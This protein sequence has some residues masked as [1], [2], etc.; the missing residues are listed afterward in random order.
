MGSTRRG[1]HSFGPWSDGSWS[2]TTWRTGA[3]TVTFSW[4]RITAATEPTAMPGWFPNSAGCSSVPASPCS[5]RNFIPPAK[6]WP[7]GTAPSGGC[8]S[9]SAA[10]TIPVKP[11]RRS[12]PWPTTQKGKSWP[13]SS[14]A[15][16]TASGPRSKSSAPA[17]R[18]SPT[19]ARLP[20]SPG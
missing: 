20:T 11:P 7:N 10:P 9:F 6:R 1:K 13:T 4:T 18:A 17:C 15:R 12:P 5:A 14:L 8:S 19:I 2:S 3:T 16:P